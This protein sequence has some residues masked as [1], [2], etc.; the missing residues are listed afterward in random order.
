MLNASNCRCRRTAAA[1]GGQHDGVRAGG[2]GACGARPDRGDGHAQRGARIRRTGVGGHH[3][4]QRDPRRPADDQPV[5]DAASRARH[6]RGQ[7]AELRAGPA[8][9]L[10]RL[11][12]ARHVR[13][14]WRAAVPG[15]DSGDDA[16]RA[17]ADRQLQPVFGAADRS[18]ARA[19]LHAVRQCV[20]WR[21]L[22]VHRGRQRG[23][24]CGV[25][26]R[27][28]QLRHVQPWREAARHDGERRLRRR[29]ERVRYRG[30]PRS[31]VGTPRCRQCQAARRPH[32]RDAADPDRQL[33][34]SAGDAGSARPDARA[35]GS[36]P[37]AG[38][39]RRHCCSIRAR[40]STRCKA[41]LPSITTSTPIRCCMWRDTAGGA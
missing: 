28:R 25:Q 21:D 13:R 9:Q 10:A 32:R 6:V 41:A 30:L 19:V 39:S 1:H 31:L 24:D 16:G 2:S 3:R 34:V 35:V 17:G 26:R 5:R 12:R 22:G 33:A 27:R 7:S 29:G 18:A 8:D 40:R 11:R 23:A 4:G 20:G 38:R 14:A 36:R 15:R 37:A